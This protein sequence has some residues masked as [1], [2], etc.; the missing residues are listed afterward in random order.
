MLALA[1]LAACGDPPAPPV[2]DAGATLPAPPATLSE[3]GLF[4]SGASGA[5]APGVRSYGVRHALWT[6]GADKR[7]HVRLPEGTAIDTSDPNHWRFPAGTRIWKEFLVE[8]RL[9]ETRMLWKT[10]EDVASWVYVAYR[11]RAD[12]S[13]ADAIPDG[14]ED[15]LGTAHDVPS[16][17][18]C[19][20][21]HRGGAD[22]VLGVGAMQL[23][24]A[25]FDA[26][27]A[28]GILPPGTVWGEPPGDEVARAALG[29]LHGN[30]GHC[31]NDVHPLA[32]SRTLRLFLPVGVADPWTAPAWDT[33]ANRMAGHHLEGAD[34][35]IAVGDPMASQLWVRMGRRDELSMPPLGTEVV[36]EPARAAVAA[37]IESGA[38]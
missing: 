12:G 21:C 16:T 4:A 3:T 26:W 19:R 35:I 18:E 25:A 22:F 14:E 8:G 38:P 13:D 24:R 23:E 33:A 7:R 6:D 34:Q 27:I 20:G 37:W 28:E 17:M 15:A 36:D 30:C 29:Y 10:G 5:L 2:D 1:L 11:H 32:D 31:H 9:V